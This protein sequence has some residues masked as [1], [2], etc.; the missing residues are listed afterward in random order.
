MS[1]LTAFQDRFSA[2]LHRGAIL[3][4]H[5]DE[6]A[7]KA[8]VSVHRNT[9]YKALM[10]ALRANYSSVERLMGRDWFIASAQAFLAEN[11][12]KEPSLM[13]FGAGYPDFLAAIP[14]SEELDFLPGVARLDRYWTEAHIAPDAEVVSA[15][16]LARVPSRAL[17]DLKLRPHPSARLEWFDY[18]APSLWRQNRPSDPQIERFDLDWVSEGALMVRRRGEVVMLTL[19]AAGFAFLQKC[20]AGAALGQSAVAALEIDA[21]TDLKTR[22]AQF[23]GFGA[24]S[25]ID[26]ATWDHREDSA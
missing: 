7:L 1:D 20:Y 5:G 10:D 24:F 18:P 19:D 9:I 11:L 26:D 22:I 3:T 14:A 23:I 12:P 8:G 21:A 4:S 17:F 13:A 6:E 16:A 15:E 2:A 25:S